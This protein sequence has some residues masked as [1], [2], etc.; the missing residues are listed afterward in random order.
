MNIGDKNVGVFVDMENVSH[1]DLPYILMEVK[2][3]GRIIVSRVYADWTTSVVEKWRQ[4]LTTYALEPVHCARLPKKNSVDIK[5]I[6]DIYD[7]LYFKR[8][9]DIYVLVS[10]DIDYLTCSRKIK[11]FGKYLI[12]FGYGNCSEVLKNVS[13]KFVNISLLNMREDTVEREQIDVEN[14]ERE[15]ID[16]EDVFGEVNID[17]R[18]VGE[19][20]VDTVFEVMGGRRYKNL[21]E[22]MKQMERSGYGMEDF[23]DILK[24]YSQY[25]RI[26]T[27][28]NKKILYDITSIDSEVHRTIDEQIQAVYQLS[29][30]NEMMMAQLKEKMVFLS[31]DF[32]QRVWGFNRFKDMV[33]VLF[34][35]KL[36]VFERANSVFVKNLMD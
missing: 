22:F 9:V 31:N 20:F 18:R 1:N 2:K 36:E 26:G 16:V 23:E 3:F 17:V 34:S 5:M 13:D 29:D 27:Y 10:N 6:D 7:I 24:K 30:T 15:Q 28:K 12:T 19:R 25:F 35:G 4:Y 33:I 21:G 8:T 11:L 32:D 14:V